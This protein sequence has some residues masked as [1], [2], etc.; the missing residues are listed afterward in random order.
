MPTIGC[1]G[2]GALAAGIVAAGS[3]LASAAEAA[4]IFEFR[5]TSVAPTPYPIQ[6][7]GW[8]AFSDAAYAAGVTFKADIDDPDMPQWGAAGIQGFYFEASGIPETDLFITPASMYPRPENPTHNMHYGLWSIEVSLVGGTTQ[9]S[10]STTTKALPNFGGICLN[11]HLVYFIRATTSG[12]ACAHMRSST[13][14]SMV[15]S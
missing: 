8:I 9:K 13:A 4:V 10:I 2:I 11:Y 6:A 15:T 3:L 7:T 12:V 5:Q 14:R 1:R